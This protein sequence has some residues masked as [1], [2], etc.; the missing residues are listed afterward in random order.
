MA[1]GALAV[2]PPFSLPISI[3][4]CLALATVVP[5]FPFPILPVW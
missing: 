4:Q 5:H 2:S 3:A 1:I